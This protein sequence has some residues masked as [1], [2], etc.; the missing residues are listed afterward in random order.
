MIWRLSKSGRD[1]FLTRWANLATGRPWLVLA[2]SVGLAAASIAL[3]VER[4]EFRADRSDLIDRSLPWQQRYL[5]YQREFPHWD[6]AVVVI[7]RA[8][9]DPEAIEAFVGQLVERLR[10]D[11]R[12]EFVLAGFPTEEAPPG[13]LLAEPW[14]KVE[15]VAR[16]MRRAAPV[17][18]SSGPGELIGLATIASSLSE[19]DRAELTGLLARIAAAA[20][21]GAEHV[22]EQPPP[23]QWFITRSGALQVVLVSFAAPAGEED[24]VLGQGAAV[25]A[26][27]SHLRS[28]RVKP[29]FAAIE[30]GVTGVPVLEADEAEQAMSDSSRATALA[31]ALIVALMM[32]VYRGAIVPLMAIGSLLIGVAWSFGWLTLS[33]GHLQLLSVVFAV[34]LL[35]LGMGTAIHLIARLELVH[36]DHAHM[37]AAIAQTFRAVG[38]GVLTASVTTAAA[39]AATAFTDFKGVA[40]MGVIAAGGVILCTISVMT[41]FPAMLEVLPA[42]E[43]R[44]RAR[45]GGESKPF[46]GG[47]LNVIDRRARVFAGVCVGLAIVCGWI[48]S[49][50]RYDPDLMKLLPASAESAVWEHRLEEDDE[51]SVWHAVVLA[52]EREEAQRL[53]ETLRSLEVVAN[54]GGAGTLFPDQLEEKRAILRTIPDPRAA[55]PASASAADVRDAA[56]RLVRRW[57]A[58]DDA[59]TQA[60]ILVANLTDEQAQRAQRASEWDRSALL[61]RLAALR[62]ARPPLA[63]DLPRALREQWIGVNGEYLLQAFPAAI[64]G[65]GAEEKSPLS[66]ERLN[67]FAQAALAAAPQATGPAIQIYE[68][69]RVINRAYLL[70]ALF[71]A[72]TIFLIVW[73]DFGSVVDAVCSLAP[74]ALGTLLL[75]ALMRIAGVSLNFANTIVMP[76][77]I[78]MGVDAG[79]HA[80]HRWRQQPLDEPAGLAGGSGRAISL[81]TLTTVIGFACMM[82]SSHRGIWSLGFVMA[83]GLALVWVATVISMP[84]VLRLRTTERMREDAIR[85]RKA[86]EEL[87]RRPSEAPPEVAE[88]EPVGA[89][90]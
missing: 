69:T 20:R 86:A 37:P 88:P 58:E 51:Q 53:T 22:L 5:E 21:G 27:R 10:G 41:C 66:P 8:S 77:I 78:G 80:V 36:P 83:T 34:M 18:A 49:G 25:E 3:A 54:V 52:E 44:L 16:E 68:S 79:V 82:I 56:A 76:L 43:R 28:L 39:F 1:G 67:P 35:G 23:M 30:A 90:A 84:A 60:A 62:S 65:A 64:V 13:L 33:V 2:V 40:E 61:E 31:L 4:L 26:L 71:A 14:E 38:P 81:T 7:D 50:V 15:E 55:P 32:I 57:R 73:L 87:K 29:A 63:E 48:G 75:L 9:A 6:D 74:V 12:F 47:A 11:D 72:V 19:Q 85:R 46:M 45:R 59:L 42:P 24:G 89:G 17:A 70:A